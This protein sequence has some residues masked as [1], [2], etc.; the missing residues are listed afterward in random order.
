MISIQILY[1]TASEPMIANV[2]FQHDA[3]EGSGTVMDV[4]KATMLKMAVRKDASFIVPKSQVIPTFKGTGSSRIQCFQCCEASEV[5][6]SRY[7]S[8]PF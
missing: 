7:F 8:M 5:T 6:T 1:L 2:V 3:P 4:V